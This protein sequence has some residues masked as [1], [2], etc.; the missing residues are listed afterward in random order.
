MADL[1]QLNI[2]SG[3][4]VIRVILIVSMVVVSQIKLEKKQHL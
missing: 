2:L 4:Q 1:I 3:I